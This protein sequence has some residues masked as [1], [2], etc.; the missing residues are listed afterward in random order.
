MLNGLCKN[1]NSTFEPLSLS[2]SPRGRAQ[3]TAISPSAHHSAAAAATAAGV[4]DSRGFDSAGRVFS[5]ATEMWAEELGSSA[6]ASTT[7][8]AASPATATEGSGGASEEGAGDGK[9]KE[10]YSKAIAYWQVKHPLFLL[11]GALNPKP[12]I[13]MFIHAY[14]FSLEFGRIGAV[15]RG[16]VDR[17]GSGRLWVCERCGCQGQRRLPPPSPRRPVWHREAS[18]GCAW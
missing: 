17:G 10:W 8:E 16:G 15:G 7:A 4:M 12:P 9:R 14:K 1:R 3:A 5:S 18:S 6:T 2:P 13:Q 11:Y